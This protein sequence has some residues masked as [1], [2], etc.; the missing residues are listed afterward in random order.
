MVYRFTT[1][2]GS[3]YEETKQEFISALHELFVDWDGPAII[4]G[5]FNLVRCS[6]DKSNRVVNYKWVDKFN[7]WIDMWALI[8][9]QL[10]GRSYT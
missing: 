1:V 7:L 4:G 10:T 2:Y 8:E 5:D 3:S 6:E 9:I